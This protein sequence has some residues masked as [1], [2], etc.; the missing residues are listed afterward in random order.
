M[1]LPTSVI[2][3]TENLREPIEDSRDLDEDDDG[4]EEEEEEEEE[5]SGVQ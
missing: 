4:D 5:R 1:F 3:L 2:L